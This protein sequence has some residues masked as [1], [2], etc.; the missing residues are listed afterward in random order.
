MGRVRWGRYNEWQT[1]TRTKAIYGEGSLYKKNSGD[2]GCKFCEVFA[3][4]SP[5]GER[6][7]ARTQPAWAGQ[8][9]Q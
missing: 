9:A 6:R 4:V 1:C 3:R 5:I 8:Q 2:L 7:D